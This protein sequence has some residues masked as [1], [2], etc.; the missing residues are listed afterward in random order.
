MR[1]AIRL[2][3]RIATSAPLHGR[4]T[5]AVRA[6]PATAV[7]GLLLTGTGTLQAYTGSRFG[8]GATLCGL[9]L[10]L[11]V[12]SRRHR[13]PVDRQDGVTDATIEA[14]IEHRLED[15]KD[16]VWEL[17]ESEAR[18]RDLLDTQ[19]NVI[20]RQDSAGRLTYVN[21]AFCRVFG[22]EPESVLGRAWRPVVLED[23]T[24]TLVDGAPHRRYTQHLETALG[25][26]WLAFEEHRVPG[27]AAALDETDANDASGTGGRHEVQIVGTD[28]TEQRAFQAE[29]AAARDQAQA[30]DRAK[31]RFLAAMSHEIRTPMNGILGMASLLEE[32]ELS[33]EQRTYL[34]AI[35]QSARTLRLLIDEILDFSKIEAGKL[36]LGKAPFALDQCV[37]ATV[38]LLAPSAHEK[39]LDIAWTI[40]PRLPSLVG[41]D[42][43]RVRQILLNLIG[44]AVKF[45]DRGGLLVGVE[46][47][48]PADGKVRVAI[49]V[50]DTGIGL[51]QETLKGLFAEFGQGESEI[52]QRRGGTGLGLVISRRL[53]IAMGG[54]VSVESEPGRGSVF[55]ARLVFEACAGAGNAMPEPMLPPRPGSVL[56]AFDRSIERAALA[57]SLEAAG[58]R[59]IECDA[60]QATAEIEAAAAAGQPVAHVVYDAG[61]DPRAA[62][63]ILARAHASAP[64]HGVRGFLLIDTLS[65]PNLEQFRAAGFGAYLVRPVRPSALLARFGLT[66]ITASASGVVTALPE[67]TTSDQPTPVTG[68][69]VL[70]AEDNAINA[71]LATRMLANAGCT[72]VHV[73]DGEDAVTAI[74]LSLEPGAQRFDLVLMD[75]HM[76]RLDGI[77]AAA[78]IRAMALARGAAADV[79]PM[80]ALTANAFAE[81]R[82]RCLAGGLDDYLAKPFQ[83]SELLALLARWERREKD[84][85]SSAAA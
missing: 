7:L 70:M 36:V 24:A 8:Y 45:T 13:E 19:A 33:A 52:S 31:S 76:P 57:T 60:A 67:T 12:L 5:A 38:E 2:C 29:L 78:T 43:A 4:R 44:N 68:R 17:R 59:V 30:A 46:C 42:E 53:A 37:Q 21:K 28:V 85:R 81:D 48:G 58:M 79:P 69:H 3:E 50:K 63:A 32:S 35:D 20:A 9:A 23:E 1:W 84:D 71:L 27:Q 6:V 39:G 26:R 16:G 66:P 14:G 62:A 15:L 11:L 41:G 10:L 80:V 40:D 82:E 25:P 72:V 56:L 75:V 83:K 34:E 61:A 73:T 74:D 55:T 49:G 77:S 47:D 51:S 65:R 64:A 22:C 18:Y 54:D